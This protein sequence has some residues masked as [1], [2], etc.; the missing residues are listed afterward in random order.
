[1]FKKL[2]S[3]IFAKGKHEKQEPAVPEVDG[4]ELRL[5][6][7]GLDYTKLDPGM[8]AEKLTELFKSE[9]EEGR[10]KGYTP[11][12]IRHTLGGNDL[13]ET[14][15]DENM[16]PCDLLKKELPDGKA[17]LET[18]LHE[19]TEPDD[20]ELDRIDFEE[21][22]DDSVPG[23]AMNCFLLT[24]GAS[25]DESG[26]YL[27]KVPTGNPWETVLYIPFGGWNACPEPEYMAAVCKYWYERYGAV[28]AFITGE[29][30]EFYVPSPIPEERI[31]E[32]A[33]EHVAFCEDRLFQCT[34][35]ASIS[36]IEDSLRLSSVWY[37]WWD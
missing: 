10:K 22:R 11:V 33:K 29:E 27:V 13:L 5:N 23:E 26:F 28:P 24:D 12:I 37:F 25:P 3:C 34:N 2:F 36:E 35:N 30:L 19:L 1:M 14:I 31:A 17:F 16:R 21:M 18:L 8:T 9:L 32:L 20:P 4:L 6:R 7:F 15:I